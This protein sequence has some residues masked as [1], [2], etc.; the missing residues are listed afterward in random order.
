MAIS[1]DQLAIDSSLRDKLRNPKEGF[2]HAR[3]AEYLPRTAEGLKD[4]FGLSAGDAK[5]VIDSLTA[6]G[7]PTPEQAAAALAPEGNN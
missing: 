1:L 5:K 6:I 7:L 2:P 3:G 4:H